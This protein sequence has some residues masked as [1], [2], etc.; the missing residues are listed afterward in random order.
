MA[1][2]VAAAQLFA[3]K[4]WETIKEEK[5]KKKEKRHCIMGNGKSHQQ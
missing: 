2:I 5:D 3:F 4:L 1:K